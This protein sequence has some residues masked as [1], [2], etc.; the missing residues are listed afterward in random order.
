MEKIGLLL[1]QDNLLEG[2]FLPDH[3][4]ER[5]TRGQLQRRALQTQALQELSS[6]GLEKGI[7]SSFCFLQF[8]PL[9]KAGGK[10]D[11]F[12]LVIPVDILFCT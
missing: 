8:W 11:I 10:T 6:A 2:V 9:S 12:C 3:M 5:M 4:P 7:N 1:V